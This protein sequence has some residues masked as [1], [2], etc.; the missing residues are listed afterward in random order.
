M[1]KKFLSLLFSVVFVV[2]VLINIKNNKCVTKIEQGQIKILC[3]NKI[4]IEDL[5]LTIEVQ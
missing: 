4:K 1:K 3:N 2:P 5:N